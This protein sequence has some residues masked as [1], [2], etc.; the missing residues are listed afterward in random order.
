MHDL[1]A[2]P[3]ADLYTE[4]SAGGMVERLLEL[5]RE[6]DLGADWEKG[7][8]TSNAFVPSHLRGRA[9]VHA[10]APGRVAGLA[11]VE[12]LLHAYRCDVDARS[13]MADG[14]AAAGGAAVLTLEGN[15]R[16]ILRV[17]RPLL[18]LLGRLSGVATRTRAFVD[19]VGAARAIVLD[20]RKT[21]PGL[22]ML[23]KYAVRCGGGHC[24]RLGLHDAVLIKDNHLASLRGVRGGGL[25][26]TVREAVRLAHDE[27]GP[28]GLRFVELEVDTLDQLQAI[29]DEGGC[30]LDLV[31]LDNMAPERLRE[32]VGRRD[33]SGVALPL[34]ASGGVSLETIGAIAA[35]GVDR[36]SVGSLTHGATWLDFGLDMA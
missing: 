30:G 36:I 23:E 6:E 20:T 21:T 8:V 34:E 5:V 18:N 10:R 11:C 15:L 19:A 22:R 4:L 3:L 33:A 32:A 25:A 9:V 2:L 16:A 31:L 1:N 7:D 13:S 14:D 12:Q 17:E 28:Q 27:A 24:H 35:S 29:L 26:Q